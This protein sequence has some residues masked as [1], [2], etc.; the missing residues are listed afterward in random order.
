M[1]T[2]SDEGRN[3][4]WAEKKTQTEWN[5]KYWLQEK[6]QENK[7]KF[8]WNRNYYWYMKISLFYKIYGMILS[9]QANQ[10]NRQPI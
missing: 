7:N 5:M 3:D 6:T 4:R 1:N 8:N 10:S 2:A 9:K